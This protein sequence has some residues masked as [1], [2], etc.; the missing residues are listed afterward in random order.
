MKFDCSK[1]ELIKALSMTSRSVA[2]KST[3]TVLSGILFSAENNRLY[4][5]S[6][7]NE[8]ALRTF[9]SANVEIPGEI[10]LNASLISDIVRKL[11]GDT[12]F[13][14]L[15]DSQIMRVECQL[16]VFNIKGLSA[17]D[18]P[19]FPE[20]DEAMDVKIN[21]SLLKTMIHRTLFATATNDNI[22]VLTGVKLE[23]DDQNINMIAIDGYRMA[24]CYEKS[25][26]HL[27]ETIEVII[28][29][30]S[31]QELDRMVTEKDTVILIRFSKTQVFF[32][33]EDTVFTSRLLEGEFINFRN[34]LPET[35]ETEMVIDRSLFLES[36]ERAALMARSGKNNLIRMNINM[37]RLEIF[38]GGE[39]GDVEEI[40]PMTMTGSELKIAFNVKFIIDA[41]RAVSDEKVRMGFTT[42]IGPSIIKSEKEQSDYT[43]MVL[44]IRVAD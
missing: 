27:E 26:N 4:L 10:V 3:M 9:I 6:T 21:S 33:F 25:D 37:D 18:F 24:L 7:N 35:F 36:C 29:S 32:E 23:I 22:P 19:E 2:S 1:N 12:V 20:V 31:L 30:K 44:P 11:S 8:I 42:A 34:I 43:Y 39:V 40:L 13:F 5:S 28:P 16:S 41:L 38:S 17:E 15:S 14:S